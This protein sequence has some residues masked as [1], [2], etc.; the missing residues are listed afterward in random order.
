MSL[1]PLR[2]YQGRAVDETLERLCTERA[3]CLIAPTGAGKTRMGA[4]LVHD[5]VRRGLRVLWV[6]H[7][8]ELI[9]QAVEALGM[10]CGLVVAGA[11]AIASKMQCVVASLQTLVRRQMPDCDVLIIDE[12]HHIMSQSYRTLIERA[13][14][15]RL[16]GL[17]ATPTR[18]DGK[19]LGEIFS[20]AVVAATVSELIGHGFLVKPHVF[21][22]PVLPDLEGVKKTGGD[23]NEAQLELACNTATLR[24]DI[25]RHWQ[26][27]S[28]GKP[29]V[30]FAVSIEHSK[31]L[32]A[33]F[34]AIGARAVH[35]DGS[36]SKGARAEALQAVRAGAAKVLCNVGIVTEGWDFPALETCVLA[37]PT[38]SLSLLLQMVGRVMRPHPGKDGALVLDHA[39]N[40]VRHGVLPWSD[41]DWADRM[42]RKPKEKAPG[43]RRCQECGA[44]YPVEEECCPECGFVPEQSRERKPVT[45]DQSINLA[46]LT[47][48]LLISVMRKNDSR[49]APLS[50]YLQRLTTKLVAG[51][52]HES[53]RGYVERCNGSIGQA[54]YEFKRDLG[55]WP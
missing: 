35:V 49:K 50:A 4:A 43:M 27:R 36:I 12:A 11:P 44:V 29:T 6:A 21:S 19:P 1:S 45:V 34:D 38:A 13:P 48:E 17:T 16:I 54:A 15:A 55:R 31:A 51:K 42:K 20:S 39:G 18:L 3:V 5:F 46:E 47:D 14:R 37:R 52:T 22:T 53:F 2:D 10:P 25:V 26:E 9:T 7:R 32:V 23:F 41:I 30:L 24:G 28:N 8:A 33:D 40:H